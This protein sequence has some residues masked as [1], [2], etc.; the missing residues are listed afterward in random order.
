MLEVAA[1]DWVDRVGASISF[2][3]AVH[4]ALAPLAL[5]ALP[6]A[7]G[8]WL[9]GEWAETGFAIGSVG[10]ALI[11]LGLG[12]RVHHNRRVF[13]LV[14]S[15]IALLAIGRLI[16]DGVAEIGLV[17]IGAATLA[18]AHLWNRH[19]CRSCRTCAAVLPHRTHAP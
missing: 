9:Y 14:G 8:A 1:P 15:A 13:M 7:A 5:A 6:L 18:G 16:G 12:F 17:S 4:C 19:L 3:C 11:S 10:V 2:A